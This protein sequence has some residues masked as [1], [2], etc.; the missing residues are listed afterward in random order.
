M[1]KSAREISEKLSLL[2]Y[3]AKYEKNN[4]MFLSIFFIFIFIGD[5]FRRTLSPNN[6]DDGD[7]KSY[8]LSL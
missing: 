4:S 2:G 6:G 3:R 8:D 1:E 5:K 7:K